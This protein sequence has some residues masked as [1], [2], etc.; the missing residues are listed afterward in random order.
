LLI[1]GRNCTPLVENMARQVDAVEQAL[2]TIPDRVAIPIIPV[3]AFVN[4]EWG[5]LPTKLELGGVTIVWPSAFADM[6]KQP[7]PFGSD[8][9]AH[10]TEVL[11][12]NLP[13]A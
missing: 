6:V 8:A 13:P 11:G 5:W 2:G 4:V 7:G 1:G 9:V 10:L 12:A 3:L